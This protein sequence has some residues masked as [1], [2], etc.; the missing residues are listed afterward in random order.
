MDIIFIILGII[1]LLVFF[2]Y[3][4]A[5]FKQINI[6]KEFNKIVNERIDHKLDGKVWDIP[7]ELQ[8]QS[9]K[10][11]NTIDFNLETTHFKCNCG[12]SNKIIAQ[13]LTVLEDPLWNTEANLLV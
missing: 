2:S 11:L 7:I 8:C 4:V 6:D 10:H 12:V 9:C 5:I 13:F 1:C 3:V